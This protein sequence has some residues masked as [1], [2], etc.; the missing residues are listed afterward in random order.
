MPLPEHSQFSRLVCGPPQFI[1]Q[2]IGALDRTRTYNI[3]HLKVARLPN[4]ATRAYNNREYHSLLCI[5][6]GRA[7]HLQALTHPFPTYLFLVLAM[8][9][10]PTPYALRV[11]HTTIIRSEHIGATGGIRTHNIHFLR[12][13]ALPSW[14][15]GAK[16][17]RE[18]LLLSQFTNQVPLYFVHPPWQSGHTPHKWD[19]TTS[20]TRDE[21]SILAQLPL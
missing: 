9:F 2:I 7:L 12:V 19:T 11:R 3:Y 6:Y 18:N 5:L 14:P 20:Y 10:E 15:T 8:G 4:C 1:R 17:K 16:R 13:A 21:S